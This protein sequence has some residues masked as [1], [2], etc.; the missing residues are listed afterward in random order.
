MT[1]K[2]QFACVDFMYYN[3]TKFY[4][5]QIEQSKSEG[6]HFNN[7]MCR[8]DRPCRYIHSEKVIGRVVHN[9]PTGAV[10]H[11]H[12]RKPVQHMYLPGRGTKLLTV[13]LQ[14]VY[15]SLH[16]ERTNGTKSFIS[17]GRQM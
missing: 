6:F 7:T 11:C 16:N 2:I 5:F 10:I 4:L 13:N 1:Y 3:K 9:I 8:G 15:V 17:N 14:T 12:I